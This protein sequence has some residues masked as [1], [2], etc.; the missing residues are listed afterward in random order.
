MDRSPCPLR[1]IGGHRAPAAGVPL[2]VRSPLWHTHTLWPPVCVFNARP[3]Y[4]GVPGETCAALFGE[5]R[6]TGSRGPGGAESERYLSRVSFGVP[7]R[8]APS[9]GR[10]RPALGCWDPGPQ[11]PFLQVRFPAA[12]SRADSVPARSTPAHRGGFSVPSLFPGSSTPC[13]RSNRLR[14]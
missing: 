7:M 3:G 5:R 11:P 9:A 13:G 1:F 14:Q 8:R 2:R 12:W 10:R 4:C 6:V